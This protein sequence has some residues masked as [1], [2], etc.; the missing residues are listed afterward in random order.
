[1]TEAFFDDRKYAADKTPFGVGGDWVDGSLKENLLY[2]HI[3]ENVF[4]SSSFTDRG[5]Y[6]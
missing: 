6:F 1:M 3:H 4:L 2:L 5:R